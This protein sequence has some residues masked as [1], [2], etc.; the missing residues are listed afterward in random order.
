MPLSK[1]ETFKNHG[2]IKIIIYSNHSNILFQKPWCK[3]TDKLRIYFGDFDGDGKG[4]RLCHSLENGRLWIDYA[5]NKFK[6]TDWSDLNIGFCL[7][8]NES[9]L[10]SD[11]A[12][13][14]VM[15]FIVTTNIRVFYSLK[16]SSKGLKSLKDFEIQNNTIDQILPDKV[17]APL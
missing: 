16:G 6:G 14:K 7:K 12:V 2:K 5:K 3:I 8:S 11:T 9:I 1:R 4:D 10:V 13:M 15:T 17:L